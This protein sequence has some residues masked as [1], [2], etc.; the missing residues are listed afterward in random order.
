M[1]GRAL[2]PDRSVRTQAPGTP[3]AIG[4]GTLA[5]KLSRLGP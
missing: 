4:A 5:R 1:E 2:S 3:I